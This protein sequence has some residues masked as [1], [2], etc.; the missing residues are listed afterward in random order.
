MES[1]DRPKTAFATRKE[2]FF[3]LSFSPAAFNLSNI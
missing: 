2:H 3:G 1:E